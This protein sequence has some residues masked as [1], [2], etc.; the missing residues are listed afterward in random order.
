MICWLLSLFP[1]LRRRSCPLDGQSST[2]SEWVCAAIDSG[3]VAVARGGAVAVVGTVAVAA[4]AVAAVAAAA[5]AASS[6]G[7]GLK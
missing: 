7:C 3:T 1:S 2:N 6:R 4:A 5:V